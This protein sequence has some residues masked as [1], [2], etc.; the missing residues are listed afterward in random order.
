[1]TLFLRLAAKEVAELVDDRIS[2]AAAARAAEAGIAPGII[3]Y[4]P[5]ERA[6][7]MKRLDGWR[8]AKI[9]DLI[10]K[11][12]W[13]RLIALQK[14][15]ADAPALGRPWSV[16]EGIET[17]WSMLAPLEVPLPGD[18]DWMLGWTR[19]IRQAID[20]SGVDRR[21]AHG[22]PHSSNVML[23]PDNAIALVDF[24]MAG[25]MDPYYQLGTQMNE[26]FQ[27]ES[28]MKPLLELHDGKFTEIAFSR[29]RLYAAADDFYWALR[30]LLLS[31]R[32]AA[33]GLE[34]LKY[35]GWRFLRCRMLLGQ[36]G[37]EERMRTI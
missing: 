3:G 23:G 26:L 8:S 22:D 14:T 11:E 6:L 17:I 16:F 2:V 31:A 21:P 37:F 4:A 7:L 32:S 1:M 19:K 15:M 25:D 35:A 28:Q 13:P 24:D 9:D 20:A 36:P 29:C 5:S 27:F 30:S 34:F 10:G 18:A 33:Q 12:G